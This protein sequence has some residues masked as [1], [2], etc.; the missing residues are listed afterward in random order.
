MRGPNLAG[1][2]FPVSF[3]QVARVT[4]RRR[5]VTVREVQHFRLVLLLHSSPSLSNEFAA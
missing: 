5:T 3:L 1:C 2:T 4:V